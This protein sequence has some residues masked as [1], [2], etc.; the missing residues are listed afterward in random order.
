MTELTI[1]NYMGTLSSMIKNPGIFFENLPKNS[2]LKPPFYF[3]CISCFLSALL[4]IFSTSASEYK[5]LTGSIYF[6]N[7][8]GMTLIAAFFA[9]S[10]IVFISP[11][12]A[13]YRKCFSI[14]AYSAGT[15]I[16]G[17]GIPFFL[18]F[19][20]VWK[21]WLIGKGL[22]KNIKLTTIQTILVIGL[23]IGSILVL[24]SLFTHLSAGLSKL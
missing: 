18:W 9:F 15:T 3:L 10:A 20:E 7:A 6:I 11:G 19:A 21:W 24:F 1:K 5:T 14:F 17:A 13:D 16:I 8:V 4:F 12:N 2:S 23:S 22:K